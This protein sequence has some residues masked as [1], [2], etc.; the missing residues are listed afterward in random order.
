MKVV[1]SKLTVNH[2]IVW[3]LEWQT[4]K[5]VPPQLIL[6]P[7]STTDMLPGRALRI[8]WHVRAT[9]LYTRAPNQSDRAHF[10]LPVATGSVT[11]CP[12]QLTLED[13]VRAWRRMEAEVFE[14]GLVFAIWASASRSWCLEGSLCWVCVQYSCP[15]TF[16]SQLS[17]LW[18]RENKQPFN[19]VIYFSDDNRVRPLNI[20][21]FYIIESW[22]MLRR[23]S[24]SISKL[25]ET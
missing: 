25:N 15:A 3:S 5:M 8:V 14:V 22:L 18:A 6:A 11:L 24:T 10:P 19:S 2:I 17:P 23:R 20:E 16:Q 21:I 1:D 12:G 9:R 4:T 7:A 13:T